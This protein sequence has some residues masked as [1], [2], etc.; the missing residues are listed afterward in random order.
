MYPVVSD[1]YTRT[2]CSTNLSEKKRWSISLLS[3]CIYMLMTIFCFLRLLTSQLASVSSP[4]YTYVQYVASTKHGHKRGHFSLLISQ[5]TQYETPK[6]TPQNLKPPLP[7]QKKNKNHS[8][9]NADAWMPF[10][11]GWYHQP[12]LK[13]LLPGLGAQATWTPFC[14]GSGLNRD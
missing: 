7:F 6:L 5:L 14:P 9:R 8:H 13:P 1:R 12:G 4:L 3:V 10:G 2:C 11:P